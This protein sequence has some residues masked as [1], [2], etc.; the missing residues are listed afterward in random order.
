MREALDAHIYGVFT[1]KIPVKILG[2]YSGM[3]LWYCAGYNSIPSR[4]A[5][6]NM[7]FFT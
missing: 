2:G 4:S 1:C 6:C 5:A 7:N 3:F